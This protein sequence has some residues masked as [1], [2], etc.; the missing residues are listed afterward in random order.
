SYAATERERGW[1][2]ALAAAG[3]PASEPV[4]GNWTAA[5]GHE[6]V[7]ELCER[8]GAPT[9]L[10]VANDQMALGALRALAEAGLRVPED[11]SVVGFD[12][13]ADA[14]DYRPPLTTVRQRFDL[15]GE[16]AV[17]ALLGD[18]DQAAARTVV[19]AALVV[20]GSTGAPPA[21]RG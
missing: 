11:V 14:A 5:S 8:E 20:R 2:D 15:L 17:A 16:A 18:A 21:A 3:A 9:A 1:R 19:P 13:V 12:D 7:R 10:F 4:R 6:A